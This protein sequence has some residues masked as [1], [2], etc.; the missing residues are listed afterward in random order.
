LPK[1]GA[2]RSRKTTDGVSRNA[3]SHK[4][5]EYQYH[6]KMKYQYTHINHINHQYHHT[7]TGALAGKQKKNKTTTCHS[8]A[9]AFAFAF[10]FARRATQKSRGAAFA[11][12]F[13]KDVS[14][15]PHEGHRHQIPNAFILSGWSRR[16]HLEQTRDQQPK[17][18]R[19]D[20]CGFF[21]KGRDAISLRPDCTLD[22]S[23]RT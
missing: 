6:Q 4:L 17:A 12:C 16:R 2:E 20:P 3:Q 5:R 14:P 11:G 10:V 22:T 13:A 9:G 7:H 15:A 18:Q 21:C 23:Y 1:T 19:R 8:S